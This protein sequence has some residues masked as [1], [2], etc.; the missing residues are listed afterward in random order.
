MPGTRVKKRHHGRTLLIATSL[1]ALIGGGLVVAHASAD[2]PPAAADNTAA[3]ASIRIAAAGDICGSACNQTASL[4]S[5]MSPTAVITA[6]DN[7]Y[8]RGKLTEYKGT[9]D[10]T[11]GK[12][13]S[14]VHPSP[15]NHEYKTSGAQGYFDYFQ[16]KGVTTGDRDKGYYS[17]DVGDWHLVALNSNIN[18]KAGSPQEKWLRADLSSST[19]PCT[20][21]YWHHARFSSGDHGDSAGTAPLLK[22][23]T[24]FKADVAVWGH[25][26]HYERFAPALSDGKK[27]IANGIRTFV[28]GTGGRALYSA[29]S[30]SA[31]PSE[32]FNNNT[33]GVGQFDLTA[34]GYS[35]TFKPVA[36]RTFT[37]SVSGTCHAKPRSN[38]G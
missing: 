27:D 6:G 2:Q 32:V 34:T 7:A 15:G 16:S 13:N 11:W 3:A 19:K 26:H 12:F 1:A 14:I 22:A 29:K 33:Y 25:D 17:V 5:S 36:G 30:R 37:D 4:V 8:D 9:Y 31:G 35:F 28:I 24:D 23:L 10:K 21:A 20:M 38:R 18:T